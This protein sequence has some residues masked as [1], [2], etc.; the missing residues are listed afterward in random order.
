M[1]FCD[2][3]RHKKRLQDD[4]RREQQA[5]REQREKREREQEQEMKRLRLELEAMRS[6]VCA[7]IPSSQKGSEEL[8][9]HLRPC[10]RS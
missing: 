1:F 5:E 9:N 2:P 6:Q 7:P 3:F 4:A 10:T 8:R